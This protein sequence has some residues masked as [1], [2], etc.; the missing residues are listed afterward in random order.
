MTSLC[1]QQDSRE[2]LLLTLIAEPQPQSLGGA[3]DFSTLHIVTPS[4]WFP[5]LPSFSSGHVQAHLEAYN[6]VDEHWR[7]FL[8]E[9]VS[10]TIE[11][12]MSLNQ[13]EGGVGG[14][15]EAPCSVLA[16]DV[17]RTVKGGGLMKQHRAFR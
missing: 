4:H 12:N 17:A 14:P 2:H 1:L 15:L 8:K 11:E 6:N 10:L 9:G 3:C 13:D 16:V 5:L 7:F